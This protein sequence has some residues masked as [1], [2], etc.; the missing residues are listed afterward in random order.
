MNEYVYQ[1]GKKKQDGYLISQNEKKERSYLNIG[2]IG[3]IA[4]AGETDLCHHMRI[5]HGGRIDDATRSPGTTWRAGFTSEVWRRT[6]AVVRH[7]DFEG[8][9]S[10]WEMWLQKLSRLG[11]TSWY[12][13]LWIEDWGNVTELFR[14]RG[15]EVLRTSELM[16]SEC[17]SSGGSRRPL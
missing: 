7:C 6:C 14:C 8:L 15:I 4:K 1:I 2:Y 17:I 3:A 13:V 11:R 5:A 12:T 16:V 10:S 9:V